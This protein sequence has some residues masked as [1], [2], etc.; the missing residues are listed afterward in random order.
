[1]ATKLTGLQNGNAKTA[2][3]LLNSNRNNTNTSNN[4]RRSDNS[5]SSGLSGWMQKLIGAYNGTSQ[6]YYGDSPALTDSESQILDAGR[7]MNGLEILKRFRFGNEWGTTSAND[8]FAPGFEDPTHLSFKIE[9]GEW[10][11]SISDMSTIRAIQKSSYSSSVINANYDQFPM[12][13]FDL[14]FQNPGN[15]RFNDQ[16]TYNAYNFLLNRNEDRRAQFIKDFIEGFYTIQKDLP[17][18]FQKIS[19]VS[20]LMDHDISLGQR[21]KTDTTIQLSCLSDGIDQKIFH[22]MHLYRNA[23]WND[24]WQRWELPDIYRYFRMIIY[25]FDNRILQMGNGQFSTE[26]LDF[27]IL[28]LEC[29]PCEFVINSHIESEYSVD[30]FDV[31]NNQPT[32]DIKVKNVHAY[33][34]D[35]LMQRVKYAWDLQSA[36]EHNFRTDRVDE[37]YPDWRYNWMQRFF[38]LSDEYKAYDSN[39]NS[40]PITHYAGD[41]GDDDNYDLVYGRSQ[42]DLPIDN[43]WHRATVT[44]EAYVINSLKDLWSAFKS[45]ITANTTVIR[46][47][48]LPDRYYFRNDLMRLDYSTYLYYTNRHMIRMDVDGMRNDMRIRIAELLAQLNNY[49]LQINDKTQSEIVNPGYIQ[50][51]EK[52]TEELRPLDMNLDR[53][54]EIMETELISTE[55]PEQNLRELDTDT[56]RLPDMELIK[57]EQNLVQLEQTL[58]ALDMNIELPSQD[59]I[60]IVQNTVKPDMVLIPLDFNIKHITQSLSNIIQN[61]NKPDM[62]FVELTQNLNKLQHELIYLYANLEKPTQEFQNMIQNLDRPQQQLQT[63]IINLDKFTQEFMNMDFNLDKTEMQMSGLRFNLSK[64]MQNLT[65]LVLNLSRS[66]QELIPI[67]MNTEL[68]HQDFVE[69]IQNLEHYQQELMEMILNNEKAPQE[70]VKQIMN[71]KKYKQ[72][73]IDTIIDEHKT[74]QDMIPQEL[75][76]SKYE[77]QM[78]ETVMN[79]SKTKQEMIPQELNIKSN[80]NQEMSSVIFDEHKTKQDL[81]EQESDTHKTDMEFQKQIMN[82]AHSQME[83]TELVQDTH[84]DTMEMSGIINDEHKYEMEYVKPDFND[85]KNSVQEMTGIKDNTALPEQNM[86]QIEDSTRKQTKNMSIINNAL[87]KPEQQ[88]SGTNSIG[89]DALFTNVEITGSAP[90]KNFNMNEAIIQDVHGKQNMQE[91][92]IDGFKADVNMTEPVINTDRSQ[93]QF[94]GQNEPNEKHEHELSG[95]INNVDKAEQELPSIKEAIT[96][97]NADM[98][99]LEINDEKTNRMTDVTLIEPEQPDD[100]VM[101]DVTGSE[102]EFEMLKVKM[103]EPEEP[104]KMDMVYIEDDEEYEFEMKDVKLVEPEEPADMTLR[105]LEDSEKPS[106][107]PMQNIIETDAM[108]DMKMQDIQ[109]NGKLPEQTMQNLREQEY[110]TEFSMK[111]IED[112]YEKPYGEYDSLYAEQQK[113]KTLNEQSKT[114]TPM[115]MQDINTKSSQPK[116]TM[117][118]GI[119]DNDAKVK[120]SLNTI[121]NSQ[122]IIDNSIS[123]TERL[124]KQID[125]LTSIDVDSLKDSSMENLVKLA[126]IMED[127]L[128][129]VKKQMKMNVIEQPTM[130][131]RGRMKMPVIEQPERNQFL[132]SIRPVDE[133]TLERANTAR[134]RAQSKNKNR[135]NL[136]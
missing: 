66:E 68:K 125:N 108:T 41:K 9:F 62:Q 70:L 48:R 123:V 30:A 21:V 34:S 17:Y 6:K 57:I 49:R 50:N 117:G 36:S 61:L 1:M 116:Y 20:K 69:L 51:V 84:K 60:S 39:F 22:L 45:I 100:M 18:L 115:T 23:A 4:N 31:K 8:V 91:Q 73:L 74:K 81:I 2:R 3:A 43:T 59:L 55:I 71:L 121:D 97:D 86:N 98:R 11:G 56:E 32:I 10:G 25:I 90:A 76:L 134:D 89:H 64:I 42:L 26:Q 130:M 95:I 106:D 103:K 83:M 58:I 129:D 128:K 82:T 107:A 7:F 127:T 15:M 12:G 85:E 109:D 105:K 99:P 101:K 40:I 131:K 72:E 113:L 96:P 80:H 14:N 87:K 119:I 88:M 52:P 13:L 133:A 47:S 92:I 5:S 46:D 126:N 136:Q 67:N 53:Q 27:P 44:D 102:Y 112:T 77:Q 19:G 35:M 75:D 114:K 124:K 37:N 28:A 111:K 135:N 120:Q 79:D 38:M 132:A 94:V 65:N 122:H 78:V 54:S 16:T 63:V 33:W 110:N 93:M 118:E 104:A 24:L 29:S